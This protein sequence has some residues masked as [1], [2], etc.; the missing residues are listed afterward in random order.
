MRAGM[1]LKGSQDASVG[2][3]REAL[4]VCAA[5][6]MSGVLRITGDPGG[7]IHLADGLITTIDT[8]GAPGPEALLLSSG[9]VTG[10]A[11]ETAFAAAAA[12]GRAMSAEL[13]ARKAVG[14][15]ELEALLLTTL[16]DA[17]FV[18]ASG[19]VEEY[20]AEPGSPDAVLA[21][22]PGAEADGLLAEAARRI[23]VLA[24]P[25]FPPAYHRERLIAASGAVRAGVRLGPAQ[26]EI[27]TLAD[28]RR[29]P[30][31][32]AFA[33]GRGVYATI[34]DLARMQQDGLLVAA[35]ARLISRPARQAGLA[36][37]AGTRPGVLPRRTK[38]LLDAARRAAPPRRAH[39]VQQAPPDLLRPRSRR[40]AGP[41]ETP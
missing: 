38:G 35:S 33:L 9:L 32:V 34:L 10:S 22:E 29:T 23:K 11:W 3:L 17:M 24:S 12:S 2:P 18:L 27:L 5:S 19:T 6:G 4:T 28:G 39:D 14:T 13:I 20:R 41:G 21:L 37:G 26:E 8:A 36:S 16:A 1:M 25:P 31:D 40:D 15:G 30:R 7:T